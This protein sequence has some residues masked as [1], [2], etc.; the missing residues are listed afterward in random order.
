MSKG[1]IYIAS[2]EEYIKEAEKSAKSVKNHM[3][4]V[5][6]TLYTD[7]ENSPKVFDNTEILENS[8]GDFSDSILS[9]RMTPYDKNIF[10][11]TDTFI[12]ENISGIFELLDKYELLA[13][14]DPTRTG[15]V[16]H[17]FR[18][19]GPD[20]FP[21]YNTGLIAYQDNE[22]VKNL[23]RDW[24]NLFEDYKDKF[25]QNLNQPAFREVVYCS[26]IKI[27][28]LP[29][30]YN[31]RIIYPGF[32]S[33][34]VKMLHG[35]LP[36]T[37]LSEVERKINQETSLRAIALRKWPLKTYRGKSVRYFL[38]YNIRK[39][40]KYVEKRGLIRTLINTGNY[41]RKEFIKDF[42]SQSA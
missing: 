34:K 14:F 21:Q 3:P 23:F 6:I 9:P 39:F 30:E 12:S 13:C 38:N 29:P 8:S 42:R 20:A 17:D 4:E 28:T 1:I 16:N 35:R 33:G 15:L 31:Y 24:R 19:S 37:S 22:R 26:N 2:G 7:A 18:F 11:D 10:I 25:R 27:G 36:H 41:L 5:E 32:A 40:V